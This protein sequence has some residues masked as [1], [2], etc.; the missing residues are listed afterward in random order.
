MFEDFTYGV[1][2]IGM[3]QSQRNVE[4]R[5]VFIPEKDWQ[6]VETKSLLEGIT[7][8]EYLLRGVHSPVVRVAERLDRV[9]AKLDVILGVLEV[10]DAV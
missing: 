3:G 2:D 10:R 8:G 1:A 9:E 7:P 5:R 6:D 4:W